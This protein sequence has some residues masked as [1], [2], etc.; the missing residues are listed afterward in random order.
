MPLKAD[1]VIISP[2]DTQGEWLKHPL[3]HHL[4]DQNLLAFKSV[5][6]PLKPGNFEVL[7]A[8]TLLYRVK[9]KIGYESHL[10]SWLVLPNLTPTLEAALA[11]YKIELHE[12]VPG[13]WQAD[14]LFPL[15]AADFAWRVRIR[16]ETDVDRS[17][18]N[19]D[20]IDPSDRYQGGA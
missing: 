2:A 12:I 14:T 4:T 7:L 20:G 16:A 11:H 9:F 3:W 6:D 10:S 8:Y 19:G 5:A 1:L 13:F 18:F 17:D 15:F